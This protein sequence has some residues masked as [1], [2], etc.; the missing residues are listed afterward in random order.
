ML[1]H[2][3]AVLG[4]AVYA[5]EVYRTV[6]RFGVRRRG[7]VAGVAGAPRMHML[8]AILMTVV[9]FTLAASIA[10]VPFYVGPAG[11]V[12]NAVYLVL[13]FRYARQRKR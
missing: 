3:L 5:F 8:V 11:A 10:A 1:N 6:Q 2:I 4:L 9:F 13:A 7:I 12:I